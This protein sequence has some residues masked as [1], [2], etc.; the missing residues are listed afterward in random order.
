MYFLCSLLFVELIDIKQ[1]IY[2]F[3]PNKLLPLKRCIFSGNTDPLRLYVGSY[4]LGTTE[5]DLRKL[6]T[7]SVK[8]DR[9]LRKDGKP[10]G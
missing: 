8:I 7:K 9:P 6:F 2:L 1:N 10:M 4:K 3:G 5:A